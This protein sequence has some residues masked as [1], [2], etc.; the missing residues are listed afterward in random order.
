MLFLIICA[1]IRT[2][3]AVCFSL[4]KEDF[5]LKKDSFFNVFVCFSTCLEYYIFCR[6]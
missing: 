6:D 2:K 1:I 4:M 3:E 5:I